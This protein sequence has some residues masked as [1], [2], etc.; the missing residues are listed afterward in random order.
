MARTTKNSG[1]ATAVASA[2][3]SFPL[4]EALLIL[5]IALKLIGVITWSWVWVLSPL[6]IPFAFLALVFGAVGLLT[7]L[8]KVIK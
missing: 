1:G 7:V 3:A 2:T 4:G 8:S 6:W 5:F